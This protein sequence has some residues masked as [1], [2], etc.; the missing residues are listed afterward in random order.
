MGRLN[1]VIK[2]TI[3]PEDDLAPVDDDPRGRAITP[4]AL[5]VVATP[6]GTPP[7]FVGDI[8]AFRNGDDEFRVVDV[9]HSPTLKKFTIESIVGLYRKYYVIPA[10]SLRLIRFKGVPNGL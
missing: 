5:P 3:T 7:W 2:G 1:T 6:S 9:V 8:V 4:K 10:T